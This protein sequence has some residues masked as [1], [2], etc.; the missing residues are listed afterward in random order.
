MRS[1]QLR[2]YSMAIGGFGMWNGSTA[3]G[4]PRTKLQ[5]RPPS[6]GSGNP[7][8]SSERGETSLEQRGR[9]WK[10]NR[11]NKKCDANHLYLCSWQ[12]ELRM[13]DGGENKALGQQVNFFQKNSNFIFYA[14]GNIGSKPNLALSFSTLYWILSGPIRWGQSSYQSLESEKWLMCSF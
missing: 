2:N 5:R 13:C 14:C 11:A 10:R 6:G 12:R 4:W 8:S 1:R 9:E 3:K 7:Q